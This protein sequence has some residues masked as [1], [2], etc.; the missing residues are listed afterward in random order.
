M[1]ETVTGA[2][3]VFCGAYYVAWKERGQDGGGH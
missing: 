2:I 1:A 3:I